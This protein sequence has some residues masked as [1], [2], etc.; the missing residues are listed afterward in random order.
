MSLYRILDMDNIYNL[1]NIK[2][3]KTKIGLE[4]ESLVIDRLIKLGYILY[5][6]N[7]RKIGLEID[8]IMYKFFKNKNLLDIRVI[9]VKTRRNYQ[10]NLMDLSID[11]KWYIVKKY[12]YVIKDEIFLNNFNTDIYLNIKV[13][14]HFDLALV[15]KDDLNIK[16]YSYIKDVN[17]LI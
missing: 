12:L 7:Y 15:K 11:K 16:I 6:R 5:K 3:N 1:N 9:E 10:F 17:L 13:D 2:I 4:G 14:I 8:I